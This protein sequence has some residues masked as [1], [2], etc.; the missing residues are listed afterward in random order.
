MSELL[1]EVDG[2]ANGLPP[3]PIEGRGPGQI[4]WQ[5]LRRDRVAIACVVFIALLVVAA[6]FAAP[7]CHLIGQSPYTPD[8]GPHGLSP[9]GI[10]IE[11]ST[12]HWLGTDDQGRDILARLLYGAQISL[13]VG[14]VAT[15]LEI[16]LGLVVGT[17]AG[18]Y[19]GRTDTFLAR[20]MDVVL[21]F[22][23]LIT[24]LALVARFG[25]S[26]VITIGVIAFFS[27]SQPGRIVRGQVLA[28]RERDFVEAARASGAGDLRIMVR[29]IMPNLIAP[30]I[31]YGTLLIP[32]N[33]VGEAT[34]S[35]LGLGV[36]V[37]KASWG[38]MLADASNQGLYTVAW[39]YLVF[40]GLALLFT[41]L[42]FNLLGDS[43]RDAL[44]PRR[45]GALRG[46]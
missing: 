10:P 36:V 27:W 22:P 38:Q 11:P 42:A 31:V 29:E 15:V 21:S 26:I 2:S 45:G 41:T 28:L 1:A 4:A 3:A 34:L 6:V 16:G 43:L 19:G 20:F 12:H 30:V 24:A 39:W 37:P 32:V 7:L 44:D 46:R 13:L 35:F 25:P 9:E 23:F 40:P 14:V 33:I 8:R 5:R 17:V 18:Y